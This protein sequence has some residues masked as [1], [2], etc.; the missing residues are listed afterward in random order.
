MIE[1]PCEKCK[2][3]KSCGHIGR[4]E[5]CEKWRSWFSAKW[6]EI[7]K[8]FGVECVESTLEGEEC[9]NENS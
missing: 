1:Y 7:K 8:L 5:N 3:K 9:D 4:G 6:R 2:N